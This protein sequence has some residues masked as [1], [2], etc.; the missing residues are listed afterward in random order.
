MEG[1]HGQ[2]QDGQGRSLSVSSIS[3]QKS[4]TFGCSATEFAGFY[5]KSAGDSTGS[6]CNSTGCSTVG[7]LGDGE[8]LEWCGRIGEMEMELVMA[9]EQRIQMEE[10]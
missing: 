2:G 7:V 5:R 8:V 4:T 9:Q 3:P 10:E 1:K 6:L